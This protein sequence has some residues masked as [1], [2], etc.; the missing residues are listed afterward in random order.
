MTSCSLSLNR[1]ELFQIDALYPFLQF[2]GLLVLQLDLKKIAISDHYPER[3]MLAFSF[4]CLEPGSAIDRH[5][6]AVA[7]GALAI[8][9]PCSCGVGDVIRIGG[10]MPYANCCARS[11]ISCTFVTI[12]L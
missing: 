8:V 7:F 9:I 1:G 12:G 11:F 5:R 2:L 3:G 6:F 4:E 10:R